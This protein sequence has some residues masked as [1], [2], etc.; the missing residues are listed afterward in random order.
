ML[1]VIS[2]NLVLNSFVLIFFFDLMISA[3]FFWFNHFILPN[4][5]AKVTFKVFEGKKAASL[6]LNIYQE[7]LWPLFVFGYLSTDA[8]CNMSALKQKH[9]MFLDAVISVFFVRLLALLRLGCSAS[10]STL[11]FACVQFS[12]S[13]IKTL[14]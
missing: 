11:G 1:F 4:C 9:S 14:I 7:F 6:K 3:K 5:R 12:N 13:N 2:Q 10:V 8:C